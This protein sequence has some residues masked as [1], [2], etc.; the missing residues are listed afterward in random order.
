MAFKMV[1]KPFQGM[2]DPVLIGVRCAD[3][4]PFKKGAAEFVAGENAVNVGAADP[5]IGG[6]G[7]IL[8]VAGFCERPHRI[9]P[10][11]FA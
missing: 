6:D 2:L 8:P 1:G 3:A 5:A 9:R 7:A 10:S 4:E 11:G